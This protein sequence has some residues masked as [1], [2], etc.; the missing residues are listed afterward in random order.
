MG[1]L[2]LLVSLILKKSDTSLALLLMKTA[3]IID[4]ITFRYV[5][6]RKYILFLLFFIIIEKMALI[7]IK[8]I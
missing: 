3:T 8:M 6:L 5:L 7:Y 1:P 2:T 4:M